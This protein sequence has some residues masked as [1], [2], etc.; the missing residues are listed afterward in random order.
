M[1]RITP[2]RL[3]GMIGKS[4]ILLVHF[5]SDRCI[6]CNRQSDRINKICSKYADKGVKCVEID[7]DKNNHRL[8]KAKNIGISK[9][10]PI[11]PSVVIYSNG[12][13]KKIRDVSL[14]DGKI[15]NFLMGERK[16]IENAV[17][18]TIFKTRRI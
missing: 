2:D 5:T 8:S 3:E 6:P 16:N 14:L 18:Q 17:K 1:K 10:P 4:K 9:Y 13:I 15:T 12:N 11:I 7:I